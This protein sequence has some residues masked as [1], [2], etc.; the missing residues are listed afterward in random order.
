MTPGML[1]SGEV[2]T[3]DQDLLVVARVLQGEA[4]YAFTQECVRSNDI[5]SLQALRAMGRFDFAVDDLG[6]G[7]RD[8]R[9]VMSNEALPMIDALSAIVH[10]Q[11][12]VKFTWDM[13]LTVRRTASAHL[14]QL[15]ASDE[16]RAFVRQVFAAT[17]D[18]LVRMELEVLDDDEVNNLAYTKAATMA[19]MAAVA[20]AMN[21]PATL[22]KVLACA[23]TEGYVQPTRPLEASLKNVRVFS[24]AVTCTPPAYALYFGATD[25]LALVRQKDVAEGIGRNFLSDASSEVFRVSDAICP[26]GQL[27]APE[28]VRCALNLMKLD[29]D[30]DEFSGDDESWFRDILVQNACS[31][32]WP[33]LLPMLIKDHPSVFDLDLEVAEVQATFHALPELLAHLLPTMD[34]AREIAEGVAGPLS[35]LHPLMQLVKG[36]EASAAEHGDTDASLLMILR[37]MASRDLMGDVWSGTVGH[38]NAPISFA[39]VDHGWISSFAFLVDAGLELEQSWHSRTLD[40]WAKDAS[41]PRCADILRAARAR[42]SALDAISDVS[43]S[44]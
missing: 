25:A 39:C 37:E 13:P 33:H 19:V 43:P 16:V 36:S 34:I 42:R 24:S 10:N 41:N 12:L 4:L 27:P 3:K 20:G 31:G 18:R 26:H 2:D 32:V 7:C 40:E 29:R 9:S 22:K 11:A 8:D 17:I 1:G 44:P 28:T 6:S 30:F 21:D 35:P 15:Q 38:G 23:G 5:A 14:P